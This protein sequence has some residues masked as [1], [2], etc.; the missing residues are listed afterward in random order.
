MTLTDVRKFFGSS[1][2][3]NVQTGWSHS[4]YNTWAKKGYIPIKSQ[5]KLQELTMG[6]LK[7]SLEDLGNDATRAD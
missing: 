6:E 7:A 3:F 2:N 1:Y 4:C 5:I